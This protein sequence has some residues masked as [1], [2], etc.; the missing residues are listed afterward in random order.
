MTQRF[1]TCSHLGLGAYGQSCA[2]NYLGE[3]SHG[4]LD[5]SGL[6]GANELAGFGPNGGTRITFRSPFDRAQKAPAP[7]TFTF[8]SGA[9]VTDVSLAKRVASAPLRLSP[10]SLKVPVF[11]SAKARIY[12]C[13]VALP[14]QSDDR[15]S[16]LLPLCAQVLGVAARP[17]VVARDNLLSA[18]ALDHFHH[19]LPRQVSLK[20][21]EAGN[22]EVGAGNGLR[23]ISSLSLATASENSDKSRDVQYSTLDALAEEFDVDAAVAAMQDN[24]EG[25]KK[26][27]R[28]VVP[29]TWQDSRRGI[30]PPHPASA[31]LLPRP[32][33]GLPMSASMSP[34]PQRACAKRRQTAFS[35]FGSECPFPCNCSVASRE[36]KRGKREHHASCARKVWVH[37]RAAGLM[38]PPSP[39][40]GQIV[41]CIHNARN[42]GMPDVQYI[43][44][45]WTELKS[46]SVAS[47]SRISSATSGGGGSARNASIIKNAL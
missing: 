6:Y 31:L 1:I 37:G 42:A 45:R 10:A 29:S 21:R 9:N 17:P 14:E 40:E 27:I 22:P 18:A 5:N 13:T 4:T 23:H 20:Q 43:N 34:G 28:S 3:T 15:T 19:M 24:Q 47:P 11:F 26:S 41:R 2:I 16:S 38:P 32:S 25:N 30:Q 12:G 8:A 36:A 33:F 44:G 39:I 35:K 46:L 7:S